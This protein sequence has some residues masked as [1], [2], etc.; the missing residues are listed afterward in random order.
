MAVRSASAASAR[1]SNSPAEICG[2]SPVLPAT[3]N[4]SGV[5]ICTRPPATGMTVPASDKREVNG[6]ADTR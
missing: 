5:V 4:A 2:A 3:I 1:S 6:A